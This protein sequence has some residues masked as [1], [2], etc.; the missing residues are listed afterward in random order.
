VRRE[1]AQIADLLTNAV[2]S[3]QVGEETL[4]PGIVESFHQCSW[5]APQA[6]G[7]DRRIV[8]VRGKELDFRG[9]GQSIHMLSKENRERIGFLPGSAPRHPQPHRSI[10][11]LAFEQPRDD[12]GGKRLERLFV[13]KKTRDPDE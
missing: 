5:I 7:R 11:H 10:S 12:T 4:A 6:C 1:R 13:P 2:A 3:L 8:N 9:G